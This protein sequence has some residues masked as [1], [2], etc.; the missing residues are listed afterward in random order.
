MTQL[1]GILNVTPDSFFDQSRFFDLEAAVERGKQIYA[2]GA[3]IIDI[4]GESTRPGAA[5]VT[6]QE[7][8]ERVIPVIK[9]LRNAIPIPISIDTRNAKV[10]HAAL[11][12][13][14]TFINDVSGFSDPDMQE[15]AAASHAQ[16]CIMH[17]QGTPQTMQSNPSYPEGIIPHLL[18]WFE[19]RIAQLIRRGIS[20]DKIFLD[21]GIGFGKTVADNLEIIQNLP[22]LGTLGFP[23]LLGI[24]RK[25]FM[26]KIL[27]KPASELLPATI[28]INVILALADVKIIRVHDVREHRD[29]IEIINRVKNR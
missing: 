29:I 17:M 2:E 25:S 27:N 6:I 22:Q 9:A 11:E 19:S 26:G 14:A 15:L 7:E 16:I 1:M 21:P 5:P 20:Q 3:D 10:A 28:A 13:G 4:G 23:L 24:S 18:N 8:L 12:A